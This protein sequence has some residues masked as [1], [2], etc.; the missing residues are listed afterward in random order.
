MKGAYYSVLFF[1][2]DVNGIVALND[3]NGVADK[4]Q[5]NNDYNGNVDN[6][7]DYYDSDEAF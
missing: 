4:I 6:V 2:H 3:N 1:C 5:D 7:V